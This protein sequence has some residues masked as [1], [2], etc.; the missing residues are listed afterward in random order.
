[1]QAHFTIEIP[2]LGARLE[3]IE[4]SLA[5]VKF[6]L[7]KL[8]PA[9]R[10]I[11]LKE[12]AIMADLNQVAAD[13]AEE[14]TLIGSISTF[15][16]GLEQQ[17]A[18]VLSGASLPPAVQAKV[19]AIFVQAEANKAALAQALVLSTPAATIPV[20]DPGTVD[21]NAQVPVITP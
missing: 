12:N 10:T 18:D 8:M 21:P 1:M 20:V 14:T 4:D 13:M 9:L 16:S 15:I 19:D 17:L 3:R 2:G 11:N 6:T 5:D 7:R